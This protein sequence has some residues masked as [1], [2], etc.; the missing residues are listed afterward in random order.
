M[1]PEVLLYQISLFFEG[2]LPDCSTRALQTTSVIL[3]SLLIFLEPL[4]SKI[5]FSLLI[6]SLSCLSCLSVLTQSHSLTQQTDLSPFWTLDPLSL[7]HVCSQGPNLPRE[8]MPLPAFKSSTATYYCVTWG[9]LV[10]LLLNWDTSNHTIFQVVV[11]IKCCDTFKPLEYLR[12]CN[13]SVNSH[14][15]CL[16]IISTSISANFHVLLLS[17]IKT[18]Q[19]YCLLLL[20]KVQV[21]EE[22]TGNS[23]K[24]PRGTLTLISY[25]S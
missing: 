21:V 15:F 18:W 1:V 12:D 17:M 9:K 16:C 3:S 7:F 25:F 2:F 13:C 11:M 8:A 19:G 14:Q 5:G 20:K 10:S 24:P 4:T 6:T 23:R 22:G